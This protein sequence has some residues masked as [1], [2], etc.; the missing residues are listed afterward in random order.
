MANLPRATKLLAAQP[1]RQ[2]AMVVMQ[3]AFYDRLPIIFYPVVPVGSLSFCFC[4][5]LVP[6]SLPCWQIIFLTGVSIFISALSLFEN[7]L[8]YEFL[9]V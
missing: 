5:M 4:R 2:M 3:V 1:A 7:S 8:Y 6:D 9:L